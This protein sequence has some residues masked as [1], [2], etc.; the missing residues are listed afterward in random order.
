MLLIMLRYVD[1]YLYTSK[2]P[3]YYTWYP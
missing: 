2:V 1:R 3:G